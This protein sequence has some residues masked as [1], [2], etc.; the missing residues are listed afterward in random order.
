M[1]EELDSAIQATY[2]IYQAVY[3]HMQEIQE[4]TFAYHGTLHHTHEGSI[5]CL[6]NDRIAAKFSRVLS[7]FTFERV[8]SA[9]EALLAYS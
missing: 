8:H 5:G 1:K 2:A 7:S 6:C 4:G 3:A 9:V